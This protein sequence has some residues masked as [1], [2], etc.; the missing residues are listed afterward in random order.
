MIVRKRPSFLAL[1]FILKGSV[2]PRIYRRILMVMA[3]SAA[4]VLAHRS[5]P[6]LVPTFDGAPFALLGIALSVFLGFS[7][8]TCYDR[9]W[10]GR[11]LWG[12]LIAASRDLSRR[13]LIL[14]S[15][16][17]EG[18]D[19]RQAL[20]RLAIAFA[21]ALVG[22]LRPG[23]GAQGLAE[24]LPADLKPGLA[25]ARFTPEFIARQMGGVLARLKAEARISDIEFNLLDG[26]VTR[27]VEAFTGCER[28]KTTPVPFGYTLLLHRTAYIFCMLLPFGFADVLGWGTPLASGLVAYT[29]FGLDAIGDELEEPFGD[30]ANDLPIV[31]M[32]RVIEITLLEGLGETSLPPALVPVDHVLQ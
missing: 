25:E 18:R 16:G 5:H 20:L 31:A 28:I 26:S 4:V 8:N 23:A 21:Y 22:Y 11:K 6:G 27:M 13:T 10:E 2:L 30:M 7:N 14:E 9:W 19:A 12:A 24:H 29:F 32:A 1:F 3:L 15:R 17:P